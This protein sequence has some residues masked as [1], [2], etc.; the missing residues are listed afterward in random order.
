MYSIVTALVIAV[1]VG[2]D[3][4]RFGRLV[5]STD[6]RHLFGKQSPAC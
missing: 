3:I 4:W 5:H 1:A 2:R 6:I